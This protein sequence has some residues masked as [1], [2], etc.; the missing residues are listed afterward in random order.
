VHL[1]GTEHPISGILWTDLFAVLKNITEIPGA[2]DLNGRDQFGRPL[3]IV[4]WVTPRAVD[5]AEHYLQVFGGR[6]SLASPYLLNHAVAAQPAA[7]LGRLVLP[8]IVHFMLS[9]ILLTIRKSDTHGRA[10]IK[11]GAAFRAKYVSQEGF[12]SVV[13]R[14]PALLKTLRGLFNSP[15]VRISA[16]MIPPKA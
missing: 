12:N 15:S 13:H 1:A 8:E 14:C 11:V 7:L 16:P 6:C 10:D 5:N 4:K 9:K 3:L 2:L